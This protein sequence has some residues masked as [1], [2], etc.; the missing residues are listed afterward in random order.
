MIVSGKLV[1]GS[2]VESS[3]IIGIV[4]RIGDWCFDD[5]HWRQD[6]F[7]DWKIPSFEDE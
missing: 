2:I 6:V 7:V 3:G 1:V 4:W 5:N